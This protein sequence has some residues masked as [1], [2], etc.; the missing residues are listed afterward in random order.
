MWKMRPKYL[1]PKGLKNPFNLAGPK[2]VIM[3]DD[4]HGCGALFGLFTLPRRVAKTLGL[5]GN[6]TR[7]DEPAQE[8]VLK[9]KEIKPIPPNS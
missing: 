1:W 6:Q 5:P 3:F 2:P 7:P 8:L 4:F 9:T